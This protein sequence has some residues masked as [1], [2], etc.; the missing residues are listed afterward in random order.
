MR[1]WHYKLIPVLPRAQL[2]SQLRENVAIAKAL[3]EKGL[4]L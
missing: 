4:S 2:V 1:L 3:Y